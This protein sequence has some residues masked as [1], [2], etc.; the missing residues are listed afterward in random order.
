M[1]SHIP[2]IVLLQ[3]ETTRTL[4]P[5]HTYAPLFE[6]ETFHTIHQSATLPIQS[7]GIL[8]AMPIDPV[9]CTF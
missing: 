5:T 9:I 7:Q 8:Q 2:D 6:I 3:Q 4:F 1:T